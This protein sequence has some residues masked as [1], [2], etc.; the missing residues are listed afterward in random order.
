MLTRADLDEELTSLLTDPTVIRT[1]CAGISRTHRYV[2][3]SAIPEALVLGFYRATLMQF[4]AQNGVD[5]DAWLREKRRL[6]D[7]PSHIRDRRYDHEIVLQYFPEFAEYIPPTLPARAVV[8]KEAWR[9]YYTLQRGIGS[10]FQQQSGWAER[11]LQQARKKDHSPGVM[12]DCLYSHALPVSHASPFY[13]REDGIP[14]LCI[15]AV[16][17]LTPRYG[18]IPSLYW[19][20]NKVLCEDA[21]ELLRLFGA[22]DWSEKEF[23]TVHRDLRRKLKV[24]DAEVKEVLGNLLPFRVAH[25]ALCEN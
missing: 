14:P 9:T 22:G 24:M 13:Q 16:R 25:E 17:H 5:A 8:L 2:K 12:E 3:H 19:V 10:D 11:R 15:E 18:L 7:R 20:C 6:D 1:L 21:A 23:D 4:L